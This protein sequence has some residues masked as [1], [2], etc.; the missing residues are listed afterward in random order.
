MLSHLKLRFFYI[1]FNSFLI[2]ILTL[3]ITSIISY[4]KSILVVYHVL[5]IYTAVLYQCGFRGHAYTV[6][7]FRIHY[8]QCSWIVF[9]N[10]QLLDFTCVSLIIYANFLMIFIYLAVIFLYKLCNKL[11]L[12]NVENITYI[13][14]IC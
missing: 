11:Y 2:F 12:L 3:K 4:R 9:K 5:L 10:F 14:V 8:V 1:T 7:N 13:E 6:A